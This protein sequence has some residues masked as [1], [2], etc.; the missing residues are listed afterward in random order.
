MKNTYFFAKHF[1]LL[2]F[3]LGAFLNVT[4]LHGQYYRN[5][6]AIG[7]GLVMRGFN[8]NVADWDN[9]GNNGAHGVRTI[10]NYNFNN[11][12]SNTIRIVWKH[13][14]KNANF[15]DAATLGAYIAHCV[16]HN[17]VPMVELHDYTGFNV[18]YKFAEP[19]LMPGRVENAMFWTGLWWYKNSARIQAGFNNAMRVLNKP[20]L[21]KPWQSYA[22]LNFGNEIGSM[23]PPQKQ[24]PANGEFYGGPAIPYSQLNDAMAK[25]ASAH[26]TRYNYGPGLGLLTPLQLIRKVYRGIIVI[27]AFDYGQNPNSIYN[28]QAALLRADP[29]LAFSIHT[30]GDWATGATGGKYDPKQHINTFAGQVYPV[31]LGEIAPSFRNGANIDEAAIL[32]TCKEKNIGWLAWVFWGEGEMPAQLNLVGPTSTTGPVNYQLTTWGKTIFGGTGGTMT[33][34][35]PKITLGPL[36]KESEIPT[37]LST[38]PAPKLEVTVSDLSAKLFPNPTGGAFNLEFNSPEEDNIEVAVF[39]LKGSILKQYKHGVV[40]GENRLEL[41]APDQPGVYVVQALTGK[42]KRFA[43]T[44]VVS[45]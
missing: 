27:D 44:L 35:R 40:T 14:N 41:M 31:I 36:L 42:G 17:T 20:T 3:M 23:N 4:N 2:A 1:L 38:S 11:K 24:N 16:V 39:D 5:G 28:H 32:T 33:D 7:L 22:I 8:V 43:S 15:R 26:I 19:T 13:K 29:Q 9:P 34:W 18:S 6:R 30:Y 45:E 21:I 37:E 10:Q 25:W 12:K